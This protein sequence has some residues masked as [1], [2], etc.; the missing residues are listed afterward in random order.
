MKFLEVETLTGKMFVNTNDIRYYDQEKN[1][2]VLGMYAGGVT[3]YLS[4]ESKGK[5]MT[6][7]Y[8]NELEL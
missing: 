1:V 3:L 2:L 6:F 8:Q 7:F 5:I 4:D